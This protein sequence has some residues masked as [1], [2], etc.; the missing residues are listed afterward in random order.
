MRKKLDIEDI[1]GKIQ[2]IEYLKMGKKTTVCLIT[3]Q[4]GFEIVGSSACVCPENFRYEIG[5]ETAY[6]NALNNL[7]QVEGYM[8]QE[9]FYQEKTREELQYE[10]GN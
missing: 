7:W 3:L 9:E 10:A 8:L 4:N 2:N 6:E 5:A 1:K